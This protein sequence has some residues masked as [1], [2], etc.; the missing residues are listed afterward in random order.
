M[1]Q[2]ELQGT[3]IPFIECLFKLSEY[4]FI[5]LPLDSVLRILDM[6][7]HYRGNK[8]KIAAFATRAANQRHL[9]AEQAASSKA[10]AVPGFSYIAQRLRLDGDRYQAEGLPTSNPKLRAGQNELR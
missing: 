6:A 5:L 9:L 2:Q 7:V 3:G 4:V 10:H 1:N 8:R